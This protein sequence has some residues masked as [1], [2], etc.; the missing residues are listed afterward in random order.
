MATLVKN[1]KEF[2][3]IKMSLEEAYNLGWGIA[4]NKCI[5]MNCN[6]F[7]TGD[8]YFPVVLNDTM[9]KECYE[10]W[11]AEAINYPEDRE[12]EESRYNQIKGKLNIEE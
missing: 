11:L 10:K 12:Y 6:N 7:I 1:S 8:L 4:K 9:D 5:C 3:V 2:K